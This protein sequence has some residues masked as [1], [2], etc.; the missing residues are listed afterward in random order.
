MIPDRKPFLELVPQETSPET[1]QERLAT[2]EAIETHVST[3][4][5]QAHHPATRFKLIQTVLTDSS[6]PVIPLPDDETLAFSNG[7]TPSQIADYKKFRERQAIIAP[8]V[9]DEALD[10]V[11]IKTP[12]YAEYFSHLAAF[13]QNPSIDPDFNEFV[14]RMRRIFVT[15]ERLAEELGTELTVRDTYEFGQV[16]DTV[17]KSQF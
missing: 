16:L 10:A 9:Q 6:E 17:V 11:A 14:L 12:A 13:E 4:F 1:L 3:W 15:K 5:E 7:L 2:K 8:V